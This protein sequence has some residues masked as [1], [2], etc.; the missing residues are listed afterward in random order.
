MPAA[1]N[2]QGR[3]WPIMLTIKLQSTTPS[4]F[5]SR[6]TPSNPAVTTVGSG[7]KVGCISAAYTKQV[8]CKI[9]TLTPAA[10]AVA[11]NDGV[12]VMPSPA[13]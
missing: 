2:K 11:P 1:G 10:A 13:V 5:H 3:S 12:A 6:S 7:W 9:L 4:M 8:C